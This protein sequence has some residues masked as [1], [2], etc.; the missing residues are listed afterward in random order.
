MTN[1]NTLIELRNAS[2]VWFFIT[3]LL[4]A[5]LWFAFTT[6]E[7][8]WAQLEVHNAKKIQTIA[9]IRAEGIIS[10]QIISPEWKDALRFAT[11]LSVVPGIK[12][13]IGM[14]TTEEQ[15]NTAIIKRITAKPDDT[16]EYIAWLKKSWDAQS[17]ENLDKLQSDIAEIIPIFSGVTGVSGSENTKHIVGTITLRSLIYYIQH[18]IAKKYNLWIAVG[19]IG[20]DGVQ[21]S[22]DGSE[23]GAYDIPLRFD[24]VNNKDVLNL[25]EFLRQT[26]GIKIIKKENN[27]FAIQHVNALVDQQVFPTQD[28]G[29]SQLSN[30]LIT[31]PSLSIT[32]SEKDTMIATEESQEWNVALTL[33]FYIRG[34][35][36]D[37]LM[38]MDI[39]LGKDIWS[40]EPGVLLKR[41]SELLE[42]CRRNIKCSD[43][44]KINE[45]ITLLN[46][47]KDTYKSIL[48]ADKS[49]SPISRIRRRSELMTTVAGIQKKL[50]NIETQQIP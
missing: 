18:D 22:Q 32:P 35:S 44:N 11:I 6:F 15:K 39:Q 16:L 46:A 12:S 49:S 26:G 24:K 36:G 14:G 20:V 33:T 4:L 28:T 21:F 27:Q 31:I 25:L 29:L 41:A 48:W 5:G 3:C 50:T 34:V 9:N 17:K 38:K 40:K 47:A 1:K 23:I 8:L 19:S 2:I 13:I 10:D 45:I 42:S 37:Q 30:L 7:K 43:E